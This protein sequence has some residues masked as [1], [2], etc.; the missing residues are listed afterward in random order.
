MEKNTAMKPGIDVALK[1]G[2]APFQ[3]NKETKTPVSLVNIFP[4]PIKTFLHKK[5][6]GGRKILLY[7]PRIPAFSC[8]FY[9]SMKFP[10]RVLEWKALNLPFFKL[11][12]TTITTRSE[13]IKEITEENSSKYIFYTIILL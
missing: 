4:P 9:F 13:K 3:N 5:K 6:N 12:I 8:I 11:H 7:S 10:A 1:F 2:I